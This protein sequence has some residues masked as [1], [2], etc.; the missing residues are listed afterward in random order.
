M[1]KITPGPVDETAWTITVRLL[2]GGPPPEVCIRRLLKTLLRQ[3]NLR[4]VDVKVAS[5]EPHKAAQTVRGR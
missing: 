4:C 2:P 3:F 1:S 5:P